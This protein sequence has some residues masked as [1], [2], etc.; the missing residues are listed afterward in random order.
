MPTRHRFAIYGR[1]ATFA[2][3]AGVADARDRA[4]A[5]LG[6]PPIDS[7]NIW[8]A[9][10]GNVSRS[11][12]VEVPLS[13]GSTL[14]GTALI[15]ECPSSSCPHSYGRFK[16][17]RGTQGSGFFPGPTTPNG[18]THGGSIM[19]SSNPLGAC[20]FDLSTDPIEHYDLAADK[21]ELVHRLKQ[22][23]AELDAGVYQSPG[24]KKGDPASRAAA[25][26]NG[27][28]WGPWQDD[29]EY[30]A[31]PAHGEGW[32]EGECDDCQ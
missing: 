25:R 32:E 31:L 12:R 21:P 14:K 7:I 24:G 16:L 4:A 5:R 13:A 30:E 19:C 28:F 26:A 27:G 23:A 18:T 15:V 6:L 9:I 20:L 29:A 1:Y 17:V 10:A 2:N 22:R 8:A 11:P 3:L